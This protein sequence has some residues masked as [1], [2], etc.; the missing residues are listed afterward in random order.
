MEQ[1]LRK[2]AAELEMILN[3]V[4]AFIYYKD[5]EG[6]IVRGNFTALTGIPEEKWKGK[7]VFELLPNLAETYHTDDME[8]ISTG[9]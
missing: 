2:N 1:T 7:T 4:P 5:V 3:S 9:K 8:V 6:R